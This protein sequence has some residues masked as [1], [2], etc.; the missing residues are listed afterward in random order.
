[1]PAREPAALVETALIETAPVE[2]GLDVGIP[3]AE[4]PV[5]PRDPEPLAGAGTVMGAGCPT[6]T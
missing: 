3:P 5:C 4:V 2:Q 1:L 6:G